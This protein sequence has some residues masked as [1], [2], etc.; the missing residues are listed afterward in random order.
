M[1]YSS[2]QTTRRP[3]NGGREAAAS[4]RSSAEKEPRRAM[5][6]PGG[7]Q[8]GDVR[9][10]AV[11]DDRLEAGVARQAEHE[12]AQVEVAVA[13]V[14]QQPAARRQVREVEPQALAR[15]QVGGDGVAGEGVHDEDVKT[16]RAGRGQLPL[17]REARVPEDDL[18]RYP[19][20]R[21]GS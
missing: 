11:H 9:R 5:R 12:R 19:G 20:H 7:G 2:V 16:T 17:E 15:Q 21:R 4:A 10:P 14:Q 3:E 6:G 18:G 1:L 8:F 13:D